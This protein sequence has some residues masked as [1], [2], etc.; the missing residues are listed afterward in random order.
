MAVT[1]LSN[2]TYQAKLRGIDGRWITKVFHVRKDAE[3]YETDLKKQKNTGQQVTNRAKYVTFDEYFVQWFET[4]KNQATGGWRKAQLHFYRDHVREILGPVKLSAVRPQH[5]SQVLNRLSENKMSDQTRLHIYSLMR[6]AFADA[7]EIFHLLHVNPVHISFKP[8]LS[9]KEARF[10]TVADVKRLLLHV[11][12]TPYEIAI[13][14]GAYMGLRVGEI[15]ALRWEDI[16]FERQVLHV[17][18]AFARSENV[19]REY[20]KG[21]R[22]HSHRIP[23]ELLVKLQKM[24]RTQLT[25]LVA[26]PPGCKMLDYSRY[27]RVLIQHCKDVGIRHIATHGLRHTSSEVWMDAGASRD[28]LRIL[29]AHQDSKTTDRYVH[30]RGNRLSKVADVLELFPVASVTH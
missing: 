22:Q 26:A 5:V 19:M 17:H 28:D 10:L 8:K 11:E 16:D 7:I 18:R 6:K 12:G 25:D 2:G 24:E 9:H 23:K 13:W 4:R 3:I 30:D 29:F 21:K 27:R 1:K 20:P 15:Q 14:L